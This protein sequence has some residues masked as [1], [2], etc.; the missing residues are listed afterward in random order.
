MRGLNAFVVSCVIAIF[1]GLG[2]MAYWA[3]WPIAVYIDN[4]PGPWT[5]LNPGKIVHKG[6]DA[7]Y[8]LDSRFLIS[9]IF[10]DVSTKLVGDNAVQYLLPSSYSNLA[11][12]VVFAKKIALPSSLVHGVYHLEFT[13]VFHVNPLQNVTVRKRTEDFTVE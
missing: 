7:I 11:G 8:Q 2:L 10:A 5:I 3:F 9:D 1:S 4:Q 12:S 6:E 13:T